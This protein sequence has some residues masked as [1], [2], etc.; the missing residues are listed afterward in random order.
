M[1][2]KASNRMLELTIGNLHQ[3]LHD[4]QA[5]LGVSDLQPTEISGVEVTDEQC[6]WYVERAGACVCVCV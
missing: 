4:V 1:R 2:Q 3:L 6:A 5:G